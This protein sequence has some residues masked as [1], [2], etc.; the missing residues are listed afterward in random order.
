MSGMSSIIYNRLKEK[1][2]MIRFS[3]C[4]WNPFLPLHSTYFSILLW[5]AFKWKTMLRG[6]NSVKSLL[7]SQLMIC[8]TFTII[9]LI[10]IGVLGKHPLWIW[11]NWLQEIFHH[12]FWTA[13]TCITSLILSWTSVGSSSGRISRTMSSATFSTSW[14]ARSDSKT[15]SKK[16][17]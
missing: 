11:Q 15:F 2:W 9:L 17:N 1:I 12:Q 6:L 14:A 16:S 10:L 8:S 3:S 7:Y 13:T 4:I 5:S